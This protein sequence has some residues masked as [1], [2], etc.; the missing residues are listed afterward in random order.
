[1]GF[2]DKVKAQAEQAL[3]KGQE[4]AK[5]GMAKGQELAKEGKA[6]L[7]EMQAKQDAAA[8]AGQVPPAPTFGGS[9]TPAAA[10][11]APAADGAE[12]APPAEG[13]SFNL[14]DV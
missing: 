6:K 3:V 4:A 12:P 11:P 5:V 2:M 7:D 14:D 13:Q 1:M 8:A 10:D 9:G